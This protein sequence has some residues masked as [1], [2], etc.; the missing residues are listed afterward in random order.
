MSGTFEKFFQ[1][2]IGSLSNNVLLNLA[3]TFSQL[4][5]DAARFS[6]IWNLPFVQ[7]YCLP[8]GH[9]AKQGKDD[10]K[11][12]A[13]RTKGNVLFLAGRFKESLVFYNEA[14][15]EAVY[16]GKCLSLA[17]GNRS[18]VLKQCGFWNRA[19][20]DLDLALEWLKNNPEECPIVREKLEARRTECLTREGRSELEDATK[21]IGNLNVRGEEVGIVDR[22]VEIPE[23]SSSVEFR[24]SPERGRHFVAVKNIEP[25]ELGYLLGAFDGLIFFI[26]R[27]YFICGDSF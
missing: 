12:A 11:S 2:L 14:V 22:N 4:D 26:P 25:G 16:P 24:V 10:S 18:A 7:K 13:A 1:C 5:T 21:A 6:Y 15:L 20:E 8:L 17:L 23:A 27:G 19:L 9:A 3:N